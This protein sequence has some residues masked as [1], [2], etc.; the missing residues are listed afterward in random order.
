MTT[1]AFG[2]TRA[3]LSLPRIRWPMVEGKGSDGCIGYSLSPLK[4]T[5]NKGDILVLT[6]T[7]SG[8]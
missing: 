3:A 5:R 7:M 4:H 1:I 6:I 8:L 2:N